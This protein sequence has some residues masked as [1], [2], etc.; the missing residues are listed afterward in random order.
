MLLLHHLKLMNIINAHLKRKEVSHQVNLHILDV[1]FHLSPAHKRV[2]SNTSHIVPG[3]ALFL[4]GVVPEICRCNKL[5]TCHDG[6]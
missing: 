6:R 1:C 4:S 2:G 5:V 3:P